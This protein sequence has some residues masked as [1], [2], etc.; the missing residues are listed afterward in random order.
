[1]GRPLIIICAGLIIIVGLIQLG[2]W[3]RVSSLDRAN[4]E[5][6]YSVDLKNHAKAGLDRAIREY[7]DTGSTSHTILPMAGGTVVV[8][9]TECPN[10]SVSHCPEESE[11]YMDDDASM[12]LASA[13]GYDGMQEDVHAIIEPGGMAF[14][15]VDAA[16]GVYDEFTELEFKGVGSDSKVDGHDIS[17]NGEHLPGITGVRSY[18]ETVTKSNTN[19]EIEGE[20]GDAEADPDSYVHNEDLDADLVQE[21]F[22][23]YWEHGTTF[24][25]NDES[26]HGTPSNPQVMKMT[27]DAD[28]SGNTTLGGVIVVPEGVELKMRG[29]TEFHGL[30]LSYGSLDIAG[31]VD[32]YGAVMLGQ[33]ANTEIDEDPDD[34]FAGTPT[35]NYNSELFDDMEGGIS[36]IIQT[37]Q[38]TAINH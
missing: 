32:I 6:A 25:P 38:V 13:T 23:A 7:M 21:Y 2:V 31:T 24:N 15:P 29:Q 3:N 11:M 8:E 28:I 33:D 9:V 17:G 22:D 37:P 30:I 26:T 27:Q 14:P 18:D 4:V 1:M 20:G 5:T 36:T 10:G 12:V 16:I 34:P 19:V 35:V